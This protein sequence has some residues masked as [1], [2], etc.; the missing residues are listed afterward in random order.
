MAELAEL[1]QRVTRLETANTFGGQDIGY[2]EVHA[3]VRRVESM[4]REI[5]GGDVTCTEK[6]DHE[7]PNDRH[8]TVNVAVSG[9]VSEILARC[10]EWHRRLC[11][12]PMPAHGLFRLSID[13]H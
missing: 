11:E 1:E 12:F 9:D 3:L 6:E 10:D 5:F 13:A 8:F 7:T 4:T 2:R